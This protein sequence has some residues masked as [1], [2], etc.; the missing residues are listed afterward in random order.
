VQIWLPAAARVPTGRPATEWW[1]GTGTGEGERE[2]SSGR[3]VVAC[4]GHRRR[5]RGRR[6]H[7]GEW[8]R[9]TGTG[10]R[11]GGGELGEESGG[12][13]RAPAAARVPIRSWGIRAA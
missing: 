13:V 1:R 9:G 3:R 10:E 12:V 8:W 2:E 11:G 5:G 7:G 4:H 6:A